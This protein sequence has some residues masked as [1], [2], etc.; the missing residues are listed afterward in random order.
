MRERGG[1]EEVG[2]MDGRKRAWRALIDGL[3]IYIFVEE[4]K[5]GRRV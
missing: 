1:G 3:E 4:R 5:G 2:W